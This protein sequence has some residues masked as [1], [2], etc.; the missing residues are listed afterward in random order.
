MTQKEKA[1]ELVNK[2]SSVGLQQRNEGI[3]CALI[4]VE[5]LIKQSKEIAIIYGF[6]FD[7]S[8]NYWGKVKR[9]IEKL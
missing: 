2:F 6:S 7:E 9:E 5:L 3:S 4:A 8:T 1:I